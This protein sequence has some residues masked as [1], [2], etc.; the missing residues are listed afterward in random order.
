MTQENGG[1][2]MS[3]FPLH[4]SNKPSCDKTETF[5]QDTN[6]YF[7]TITFSQNRGVYEIIDT[8]SGRTLFTPNSIESYLIDFETV[9][10]LIEDAPTKTFTMERLQELENRFNLHKILQLSTH[11]NG[12][13]FFECCKV[14]THIH[15]NWAVTESVLLKFIKEHKSD[16]NP[17]YE[18]KNK[19]KEN[20]TEFCDDHKINLDKMTL[21]QIGE[22]EDKNSLSSIFLE[23]ENYNEGK[24]FAELL[25][26]QFSKLEETNTFCEMRL[27]VRGDDEDEWFK[28]SHWATTN[29]VIS[30]HNKFLIE[31]HRN[32]EHF[33]TLY[34][35]KKSESVNFAKYISN[36][37]HPLFEA[38][39]HTEKY[40]E[41]SLFLQQISGFDSDG[42]E[43]FVESITLSQFDPTTSEK[44][45]VSY[46]IYLYYFYSNIV[47]LNI[48]RTMKGLNT[49]D[50]RPH[51]G[52]TGHYSHLIAGYLM[53]NGVSQA[54]KLEDNTT[55]QY[56]F[57]L[58]QLPI[59]Q[60]PM[61]THSRNLGSYSSNPFNNFFA[62]GLN[63]SLSTDKPLRVH[64][65][66]EPLLEE[67][68][69]AQ[70][71]YKYTDDD[72]VEICYNSVRQSGFSK[73]EKIGMLNLSVTNSSR[74]IFRKRLLETESEVLKALTQNN[75]NGVFV[76]IPR[77]KVYLEFKTKNE[78]EVQIMRNIT[79]YISLREKYISKQ[80]DFDL[81]S[82]SFD[83]KDDEI[84]EDKPIFIGKQK[85]ENKRGKRFY[86]SIKNG[87]YGVY[88]TPNMVC[89]LCTTSTTFVQCV[90]CNQK[91]CKKCFENT[92]ANL[93]H[94]IR[95]EK[96]Q[97]YFP[98]IKYSEFMSD[99][100]SLV[101]FVSGGESRTFGYK[102]LK[103]REE[104]FKLH[105][106]LNHSTE[107]FEMKELKN[108]FDTSVKI[109]TVL[110]GSRSFHPKALL[111]FIKEKVNSDTEKVVFK[112]L[113]VETKEGLTRVFKNVT[114]K[115]AMNIFYID[116][117]K[118]TLESLDVTFD[119]SVIQRYDLWRS[120]D[121]LFNRREMRNL[122]LTTNNVEKG[123]YYGELLQQNW[124]NKNQ[125]KFL[126]S[127]IGLRINGKSSGDILKLAK[128]LDTEG[129]LDSTENIL[130]IQITRDYIKLRNEK[131]VKN[132]EEIICNIFG[133][134][135]EATLN[136][137]E[138][139]EVFKFLLR[140]GSFDMKGDESIYSTNG[141]IERVLPSEYKEPSE[142]PFQ[143]WIFFLRMNIS[144]LNN[145]RKSLRLN[146][147]VFRPHCGE[148]GDPMHCASAFL[149][150]DSIS[151]GITLD[152]QNMLQYLFILA[153]IGISCCPI[154]DKFL[155]DSVE[156]P[157]VKYF[158]RGMRVTLATDAPM[159]SHTTKQPLIEE[160]ANAVKSFKLTATD[161]NE[162]A[163]N[164][165]IISSYDEKEKMNWLVDQDGASLSVPNTRLKYREKVLKTDV[166]TLLLYNIGRSSIPANDKKELLKGSFNY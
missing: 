90:D 75:I 106:L 1:T 135:L 30:S 76:D 82:L 63:V 73:E 105:K 139:P 126:K 71:M 41:L 38:T 51:C 118:M 25:K 84:N 148:T 52:K 42:E 96:N 80:D 166:N 101:N 12:K 72:L 142:P 98:T 91:L 27:V 21:R 37:F 123:K 144:V 11:R 155:Y 160:Y 103:I 77:T 28:L 66:V 146:T 31:F 67:Y 7:D 34:N 47:S 15:A 140:V 138:H 79:Y 130:S 88:D 45:N 70:N 16:L 95:L 119:P 65:T 107:A 154:Y 9:L 62:V 14:D 24:L 128:M 58:D 137:S 10:K 55:L 104:L 43:G 59:S 115:S 5:Q 112:Q 20:L 129:I 29:N 99:Y 68:S 153:Q 40:K 54:L 149:T 23:S 26:H 57:Y 150:A 2:F 4:E 83:E 78:N 161:V 22:V 69:M 143:Y 6:G 134:L 19:K 3:V 53:T 85:S 141:N 49:F 33:V 81:N 44:Q 18:N 50:F 156:H 94:S 162:I 87:V 159:H 8:T 113:E 93:W 64:K 97:E 39:L 157:F 60:A 92:H 116:K 36:F 120:R 61:A 152:D 110:T 125:S 48:L 121:R 56:L 147:F 102:Q 164:S 117:T 32:Y 13:T 165:V 46:Y 133:P 132:F 109:D 151:H 158:M 122:F 74:S 108:D 124:F 145:L 100:N 163:Q 35:T 89:D 131:N 114:L 17:I 127:E 86:C 111:E 136:P